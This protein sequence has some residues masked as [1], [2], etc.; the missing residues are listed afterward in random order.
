[1]NARRHY[2]VGGPL[3][4]RRILAE[5]LPPDEYVR[6]NCGYRVEKSAKRTALARAR[7]DAVFPSCAYLHRDLFGE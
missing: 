4:G 7:G 1:M 6:Y 2:C 5:E 3:D